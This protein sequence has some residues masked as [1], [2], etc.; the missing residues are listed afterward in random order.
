MVLHRDEFRPLVESGS[1]LQVGELPGPHR[2]S[3]DIS[4]SIVRL[5]IN[6]YPPGLGGEIMG[7]TYFPLL[8]RSCKASMVS[9]AGVLLS[10]LWI[11]RRST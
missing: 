9:S 8:T 5:F 7:G 6:L 3:P 11:W 1:V 2:G 4:N 10:Y